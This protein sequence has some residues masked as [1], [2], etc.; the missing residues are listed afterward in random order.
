M[1]CAV[2]EAAVVE[3]PTGVRFA[4]EQPAVCEANDAFR[5]AVG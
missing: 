2:D 4:P 5:P 1:P 3:K